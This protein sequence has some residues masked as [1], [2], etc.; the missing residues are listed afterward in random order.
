MSRPLPG[1]LRRLS[2]QLVVSH[3]LVAL[4]SLA[5]AGLLVGLLA[6]TLFD[7][8]QGGQHGQGLRRGA[9]AGQGFRPEVRAAVQQALL[10]GT[11][12]GLLAAILLGVI[13]AR[14]VLNP[15]NAVRDTT[16]SLATGDYTAELPK[17]DTV[18]LA[19]LVDDVATM[20]ARL[21]ETEQ[22]RVR[23]LGEVG[24]EM[25][26][27]LTVID[28]QIEAMLDGVTPASPENLAL[29]ATE[30]RRLHRLTTDL[31]S[32]SR[33]EEGRI[34][35]D[36]QPTDLAQVAGRVVARLLPQAEDAGIELSAQSSGAVPVL[37]DSD[38]IGQ[39][40]TNLVGN[41]IRATPAGGSIT[42]RTAVGESWA[43]LTVT[44][45]G[46][47]IAA[48][49]LARIFERFYRVPGRRRTGNDGG[50][51]I[52]LTIARHLAEQHG[53]TVTAASPGPGRGSSFTLRLPLTG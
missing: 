15:I 25:R 51:G 4:V 20:A 11:S 42:V 18:E 32:L 46:E 3:V 40:V 52:G 45:T 53:G 39:V 21:D 5:T 35:L 14:R 47:G 1:P 44:D 7:A 27:P 38:R 37:V 16:R 30:S 17:P 13:A 9:G 36:R 49:D 28:T 34:E 22:R 43:E 10:W 23:L 6:P 2:V 48:E 31:S 26:T 33:A 29:I 12:A 50:S 8:M 19:D 24:H 41:A